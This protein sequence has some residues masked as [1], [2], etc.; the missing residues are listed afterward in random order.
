MEYDHEYGREGD[1]YSGSKQHLSSGV[2]TLYN[3][4]RC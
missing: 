4:L 1:I 3:S 2:H